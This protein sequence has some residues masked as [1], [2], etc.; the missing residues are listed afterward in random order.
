MAITVIG[1]LAVSTLLT[2]FVIPVV[3]ALLDRRPDSHYVE[4]VKPIV[5][6][7][8]SGDGTELPA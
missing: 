6:D 3:Y 1:G 2:L 4:R 5:E 8:P 7:V